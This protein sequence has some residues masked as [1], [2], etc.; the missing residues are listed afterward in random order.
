[1]RKKYLHKQWWFWALLSILLIASLTLLFI[2]NDL[3]ENGA[4][5]CTGIISALA[6]L[7]IGIIA[8]WQNIQQQG[9]NDNNQALLLQMEKNNFVANFSTM[10]SVNRVAISFPNTY[11]DFLY[12]QVMRLG[13]GKTGNPLDSSVSL[14]VELKMLNH[15][16]PSL[17]KVNTLIINT[18]P[19]K[20]SMEN[21]LCFDAH[22]TSYSRLS[23]FE[24]TISF[25]II[26]IATKQTVSDIQKIFTSQTGKIFIQIN[27]SLALADTIVTECICQAEIDAQT[28]L[29]NKNTKKYIC[30]CATDDVLPITY[31]TKHEMIEDKTKLN[32]K[33]YI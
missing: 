15:N 18:E 16:V 4:S 10:V 14:C 11:F 28:Y 12:V 8:L 33:K 31:I 32:I 6:T 30:A 25:E 1:M 29:Y 24:N 20:I 26:A 19:S 22:E 23:I 5:I 3:T 2:A 27:F 9:D 7:I 13:N 21:M 17:V